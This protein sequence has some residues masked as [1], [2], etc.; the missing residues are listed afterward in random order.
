MFSCFSTGILF[1][2]SICFPLVRSL[3]C[4]EEIFGTPKVDDCKQALLEIPFARQSV[5]SYQSQYSHLF[6]EPQFQ[7][8]PFHSVTNNLRPQAI[9]QLPKIWKHYSCR[10]ALMSQG[11]SGSPGVID[12]TFTATWRNVIDRSA[13]LRSC[14]AF[15]PPR[16]GWISFLSTTKQP[17]ATLYMYDSDS[18]FSA[19]INC[20]MSGGIPIVPVSNED[21]ADVLKNATLRLPSLSVLTNVTRTLSPSEYK[22]LD[23]M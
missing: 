10:I 19:V 14:F 1:L 4:S 13:R 6:A 22:L 3:I 18:L 17:A 9:I 8:P 5:A 20:Y 23:T 7:E 12:P 21:W 11:V 2:C 15:N 16:G